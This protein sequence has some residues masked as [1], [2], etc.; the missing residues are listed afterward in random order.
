ML[1]ELRGLEGTSNERFA[2]GDAGK[3]FYSDGVDV[4]PENRDFVSTWEYPNKYCTGGS[5]DGTLTLVLA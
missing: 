5:A 4:T 1:V 2:V 3:T